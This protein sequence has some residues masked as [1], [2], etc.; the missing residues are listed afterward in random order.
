MDGVGMTAKNYADYIH[1]SG[2][3][4]CVVTADTPGFNY[5]EQYKIL[6]YKSFPI[7]T[8]NPYRFGLPILDRRFSSELR[9]TQ[10][11]IIHAHC[12]FAT[13]KLAM[14]IA[15]EQ[16]IPVV[17][18]FHS[19]YRQDFQHSIPIN[20]VVDMMVRQIVKFYEQA[21]EVWIPQASVEPTLREYGYKGQV[22]VVDNGND[23]V[24]S[25]H[26]YEKLRTEMRAELSINANQTMLLFVGQHIW[27]KNI[28][29]ILDSLALIKHL[30]FKLYMI[31][32][33]YAVADIKSKIKQLGLS[34]KV[35]MVGNI[36]D[37]NKLK[38]YYA[39][40][41]MFL[42]PSLYDNAPLVVREA[43]ALQTPA[44]MI[45]GST[46]AE[47]IRDGDNGFLCK[48]DTKQY[49]ERIR[50][51]MEHQEQI[52]NV[53]LRA[54]KTI[55]RSWEDVVAEVLGRYDEIIKS[56]KRK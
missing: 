2:K 11:D 26:L 51:L 12:P 24:T 15:K 10:F 56:Y 54:S 36:L 38:R 31:G 30:P 23:F 1:Q 46:A 55:A 20:A 7:P 28:G 44:L 5:T 37:R 6:R 9:N 22:Q 13:G 19:K 3:G 14:K 4:V 17:A 45:S 34:S 21:D 47:I 32:T 33:G 48:N 8:R 53:G 52:R 50:Y 27:E 39:A 40:A 43:A 42:F 25:Q 16:H 29:F 35:E 18:T 49:A 41:D